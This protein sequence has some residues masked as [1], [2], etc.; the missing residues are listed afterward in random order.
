MAEEHFSRPLWKTGKDLIDMV[1]EHIIDWN[2]GSD[3]RHISLKAAFVLLAVCLQKSSQK[4]AKEHQ[5]CLAKRFKLWKDG[6]IE[7]LVCEGRLIQRRLTS[8]AES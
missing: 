4:S 7:V 2:N 6:E 1:T 5:E 3:M 8:S